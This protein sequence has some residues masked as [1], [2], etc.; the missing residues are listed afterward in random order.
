MVW[1]QKRLY[2]DE[3]AKKSQVQAGDYII[4]YSVYSSLYRPTYVSINT[5]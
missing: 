5:S 2:T 4:I 1:D 3:E